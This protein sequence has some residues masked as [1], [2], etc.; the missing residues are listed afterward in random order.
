M[1]C[2]NS[3]SNPLLLKYSQIEFAAAGFFE[4][5]RPK[6]FASIVNADQV[7]ISDFLDPHYG[8]RFL[9]LLP[10]D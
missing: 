10:K 6:I 8:D 1:E 9:C 3:G 7:A 5:I 4:E 2:W